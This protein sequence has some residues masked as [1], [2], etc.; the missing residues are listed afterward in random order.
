MD[1]KKK[2]WLL[3]ILFFL[4]IVSLTGSVLFYSW[5]QLT[6]EAQNS[7]RESFQEHFDII[8]F[9]ALFTIIFFLLI[10]NEIFHN[11]II[12][13]YKLNE[14]ATLITTLNPGHQIAIH[15]SKEVV[16]LSQ[17]IDE[18]ANII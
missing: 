10:H 14:K 11:Y 4:I 1:L 2:Y 8:F 6:I 3:A 7:V 13:L 5:Q 17:R 12:P 9:G 18:A 15:G 16:Q